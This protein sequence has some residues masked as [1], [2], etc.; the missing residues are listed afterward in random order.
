MDH[1]RL[2]PPK[3]EDIERRTSIREYLK[4]MEFR[5]IHNNVIF[6]CLIWCEPMYLLQTYKK[7]REIIAIVIIIIVISD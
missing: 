7:Q 4:K 6:L 3:I 1:R 2:E 5:S